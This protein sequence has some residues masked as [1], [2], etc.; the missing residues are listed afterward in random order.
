VEWWSTM[1]LNGTP[2]A[3]LHSAAPPFIGRCATPRDD[4]RYAGY[5]C[6]RIAASSA[7]RLI[8]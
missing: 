1:F 5:L 6:G 3:V 2:C 4:D 8:N 7:I